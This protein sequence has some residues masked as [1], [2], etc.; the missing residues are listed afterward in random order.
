[1]A[2]FARARRNMVDS[3]IRTNKVTDPGIIA[4]FDSLPRESFVDATLVGVAYVDQDLAVA[5][6]RFLMEPRVMARML[7]ALAIRSDEVVLDVG[8]GTGYSSALMAQLAATVVALESD[9]ELAGRATTSLTELAVDNAVVVEGPLDQGY[10]A[11]APYDV[12][13]LGGTVPEIPSVITDQLAEGGRACAVVSSPG[14]GGTAMLCR[15]AGGATSSHPLFDAA[16]APL[17]GFEAKQGFTF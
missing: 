10:G 9:T 17:P 8:C 11:Q 16:T 12:I 3:Q 13:F 14:G 2:D 5:P 1:M 4:A 6:G 15:R 7:E